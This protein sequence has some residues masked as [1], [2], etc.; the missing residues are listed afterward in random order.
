MKHV[1]DKKDET[2]LSPKEMKHVSAQKR[3]NMSQTYLGQKGWN[4]SRS[5]RMK[6]VSAKKEMKH[7]SDMS[8]PKKLKHVS[9]KKD[10]TCLRHVSAKKDE[11]VNKIS[12]LL[13]RGN[14][15]ILRD[16]QGQFDLGWVSQDHTKY[17]LNNG[18]IFFQPKV[19]ILLRYCRLKI[20]KVN[21][22]NP[23]F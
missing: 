12:P 5:K 1:S 13:K 10:E 14:W 8:R 9:A 22:A 6:H 23:F 17:R 15:C 3:W 2:C 11:I 19:C 7:V 18:V 4:M 21:S 20:F 16:F